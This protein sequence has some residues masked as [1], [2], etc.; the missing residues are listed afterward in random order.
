MALIR[1]ALRDLYYSRTGN[2]ILEIE[3]MGDAREL[4][5]QFCDMDCDIEIKKHRERR[6]LNAN[7]YSWA[8][9]GKLADHMTVRGMAFTKDE[10][11][12]EMI[13]RY[14]QVMRDED[15]K[16]VKLSCLKDV[17]MT[18]IYPYAKPI[19]SGMLNGQEYEHYKI[20]RGS[21]T[22]DSR[23]MAIFIDGIVSECREQGIETLS[24]R[25]LSLI[26]E[27]WGK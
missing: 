22:Y 21:S 7:N 11:H 25:E 23:E 10:M 17:P 20:Y 26:K 15:G 9:T 19:G 4:F 3:V 24:E 6:S 18:D 14:G 8:L 5:N 13:F 16:A 2:Q 1:G 12:A 27:G